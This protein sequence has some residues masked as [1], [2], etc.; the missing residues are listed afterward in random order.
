[1]P[2]V[3][4]KGSGI[5]FFTLHEFNLMIQR[6]QSLFLLLAAICPA[7][8]FLLPFA[9]YQRES[10]HVNL[11]V[12]GLSGAQ[13]DTASEGVTVLPSIVLTAFC[14]FLPI[15]II[16]LYRKRM[17]QIKLSRLAIFMN[18]GLIVLMFTMADKVSLMLSGSDRTFSLGAMFPILT[19]IF[20]FLAIRFIRKDEELVRSADRI[21]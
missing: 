11:F 10:E 6:I 12:C 1:M 19:I 14:I 18:A 2:P 8:L 15:Y 9:G 13:G 17:L 4:A 7:L 20:L 3:S 16:F 5:F 21:R